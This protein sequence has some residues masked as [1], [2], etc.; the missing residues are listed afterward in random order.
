MREE[1]QS[2]LGVFSYL[3]DVLTA[4]KSLNKSRAKIITVYSPTRRH[5]ITEA[6]DLGP[7]PVRYFTLAGGIVGIATGL[8]LSVYTALQWKFIIQ[9]KP[10]VPAVP[11]VIEAFEFCI[12]LSVL[13]NLAGLLLNTR[14]PTIRTPSHYDARFSEDRFGIVVEAVE[15]HR[16]AI[17]RI[18]KDSG[19]EEVHDITG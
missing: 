18:L 7:S 4:I 1:Q 17:S 12:L 14:L 10:P 5:E 2:I 9:G 6:L 15:L 16:E 3:D 13:F 8:G 11:Y 19:A